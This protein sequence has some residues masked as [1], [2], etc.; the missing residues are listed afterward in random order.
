M[1]G[2]ELIAGGGSILDCYNHVMGLIVRNRK[3]KGYGCDGKSF[4]RSWKSGLHTVDKT[5]AAGS[6]VRLI[7]RTL[8]AHKII[9]PTQPRSQTSP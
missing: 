1:N 3:R 7:L 6:F 4:L 2:L 8:S 9:L 5:K